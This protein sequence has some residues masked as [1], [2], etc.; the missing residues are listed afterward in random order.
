VIP[1]RDELERLSKNV[2]FAKACDKT[3]CKN[4]DFSKRKEDCREL[5]RGVLNGQS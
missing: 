2:D 1:S 4:C 5:A 3:L